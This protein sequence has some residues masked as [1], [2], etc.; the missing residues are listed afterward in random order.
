ME[1]G[2]RLVFI[3]EGDCEVTFINKMIIPYLYKYVGTYQWS[4]NAQKITTN[5]KLNRKGGNVNY[6]Y[7]KNEVERVA[8]Q[9]GNVWITTFLDFFRLPNDFPNYKS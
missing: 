9:Q 3:V 4:M 6:T 2:N 1:K 7:L 8:A 5:R